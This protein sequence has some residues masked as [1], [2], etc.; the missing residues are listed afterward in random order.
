MPNR[1][2]RTSDYLRGRLGPD[3]ADLGARIGAR[4]GDSAA[5]L[6]RLLGQ[7]GDLVDDLAA[8]S[9]AVAREAERLRDVVAAHGATARDAVR[10]APRFG[11]IVSEGLLVAAAYRLHEGA[12]GPGA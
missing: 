10:A 1:A 6:G 12:G 2:R 4:V 9:V 8:D 3:L 5:R 7:V 11:R